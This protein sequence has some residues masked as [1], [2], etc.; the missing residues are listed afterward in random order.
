[1]TSI[2]ALLM[3]GAAAAAPTFDDTFTDR[4]LRIDYQLCGD[5]SA[6]HIFLSGMK[7][8]SIWAGRRHRLT[9]LPLEGRGQLTMTSAE[10]GDTLYRTSFCSLFNEWLDTDEAAFTPRA[11]EHTVLVPMP[12]EAVNITLTL[13]DPHRKP[14]VTVSHSVNPNDILI[15]RTAYAL[16]PHRYLHQGNTPDKA[17]D[18][19]ILAEGYSHDQL[20]LFYADALTAV[21]SI[22]SHQPF[23]DSKD[24][25][26][27]VAVASTTDGTDVSRPKDGQWTDSAFGSHFSTF[28]SD[29]YLTTPHVFAVNDALRGIPYEHIII[30]AN[31]PEYGG[32]GIYNSYTLTT[33]RHDAFRPVVTHEFGHSFGGLADEYFHDNEVY[34]NEYPLDVEP[35]ERNV[36][37][38]TDFRDKWESLIAADTPVPT[39]ISEE[40]TNPTGVYEGGAYVS[41]GVYR[42]TPD[43]RMKTNTATHFCPAC[44]LALTRLIDF[45]TR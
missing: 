7:T 22:L 44:Q 36:T 16:P 5:K 4:T 35:W 27:F 34:T 33:S 25:F 43:C 3:A 37:T 40:G 19:A 26:N 39:A 9:E 21:E 10:T 12:K 32:G 42:S 30:L 18:V 15:D 20:E 1:M 11:F 8:D 6:Q 24:N 2:F 28:Y 41:K 45:Y 13:T 14:T 17:I 38:L 23:A 29:R 31:T